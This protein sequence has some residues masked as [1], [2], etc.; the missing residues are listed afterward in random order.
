MRR[1]LAV[2]WFLVL[3]ILATEIPLV[4]GQAPNDT[5]TQGQTPPANPSATATGPQS[6]LLKSPDEKV[7]L[8]A[9]HDLGKAQD[10]SAIP[11]LAEA[12]SD[13][14]QKVRHEVILAL[15]QIHQPGT[16]SALIKATEDADEGNRVL[17]VQALVGYY[18]GITP[19]AGISGFLKKE[20]KRAQPHSTPDTTRINPGLS[21]DPAVIT[22]LDAT[23]KDTRS[24]RASRE[25]AKGLGILVAQAAVPDLIKAAHSS[26]KFLSLGALNALSKI[27]D[28]S[29]GGGLVD[30]LDS[31]D[32]DVR[33]QAC[34]TIGIL[35][36]GQA[37]AKLQS[38]F[39]SDPD[40]KSKEKAMEGLAYL[41]AP[42]SIPLFTRALESDDRVIRTS[43]A[44]GLARTADPK[45]LSEL[46][47][48]MPGE[49]DTDTKLAI[50]FAITALGKPDYLGD[51]VNELSSKTRADVAQAY[52]IELAR[53][54]AF[55]PKLYP[56]LQSPNAGVRSRLCTV[57][58]FSGDQTS[59]DQLDRLSHDPNGDV[60]AQAL[61]AKSALRT[62]LEAAGTTPAPGARQ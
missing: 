15:I 30:L 17:A 37:A 57:L 32:K 7:R 1:S 49:R 44:E 31:P 29:A 61:R 16:L 5:T 54:S 50:E 11:A 39:E 36:T 42:V 45:T 19:T 59:L 8:R 48:A 13:P 18:T 56:Y 20:V 60:S 9:A 4:F 35:R 12:L 6:S 3:L 23:M 40:Q 55:L 46:E 25:A 53:T 26:D 10:A 41:G 47:K 2:Y 38:I 21:V 22:A 34:V 24:N 43:A 62:R 14:S 52:L 28:R 27:E 58:M 51:L 33:Q